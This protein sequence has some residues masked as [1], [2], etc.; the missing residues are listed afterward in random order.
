[1]SE[2]DC[3]KLLQIIIT[4]I[5][6]NEEGKIIDHELNSPFAYLQELVDQYRNPNKCSRGSD[7]ILVGA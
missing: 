1:M 2:S 7:Q 5:I 4:R 6:I 3:T